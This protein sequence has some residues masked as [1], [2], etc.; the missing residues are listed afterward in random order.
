MKTQTH[1]PS[2][3]YDD[4]YRACGC[5]WGLQPGSLVVRLVQHVHTP[6]DLA[7]LDAGCG[8]GKNAIHLARLGAKVRGIDVCPLAIENAR[9]AWPDAAIGCC[10]LCL[11]WLRAACR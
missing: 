2:G 6:A 4:G 7:V 9:K 3:G 5:F 11:R 8:E 1:T 10:G